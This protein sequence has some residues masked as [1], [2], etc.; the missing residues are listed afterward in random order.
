MHGG[1]VADRP[2]ARVRIALALG[3]P[4]EQAIYERWEA[5]NRPLGR[6]SGSR[7]ADKRQAIL[8]YFRDSGEILLATESAAEGVN[9]QFCSLV[10]NYD[11][12]WNPNRL[13]QRFQLQYCRLAE[14]WFQLPEL[15]V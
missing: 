9:L 14:L 15:W 4:E 10:I 12:P 3:G 2:V 13:E 11:L 7:V 6:L 8:E 5:V 1:L